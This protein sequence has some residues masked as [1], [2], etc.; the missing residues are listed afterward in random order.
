MM[1]NNIFDDFAKVINFFESPNCKEVLEFAEKSLKAKFERVVE[2]QKRIREYQKKHKLTDEQM[3]F[4]LKIKGP[5][6]LAY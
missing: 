5:S 2:R 3:N 6:F 1:G 4:V